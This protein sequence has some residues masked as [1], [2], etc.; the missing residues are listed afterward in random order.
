[1]NAVDL[2]AIWLC[3]FTVKVFSFSDAILE[4]SN[5]LETKYFGLQILEQLIQTRWKA[6]PREQCEGIKGYIVSMILDI[7]ADANKSE[8]MKL[9]L[10]K[11]NIVLVQI[12]KHEWPRLC[13]H[14]SQ[15]LLDQAEMDNLVLDNMT[16]ISL[17][18]RAIHL[19][20]QFCEQFESVHQLCHEILENADDAK[21]IYSTLQT[22]HGFL[23]WI[24]VGYIFE[25][26]MIDLIATK[27]PPAPPRIPIYCSSVLIEISS[28]SIDDN[29]QYGGKL[30]FLIHKVMELCQSRCPNCQ[31]RQSYSDGSHEEQNSFQIWRSFCHFSQGAFQTGRDHMMALSYLIKISQVED[32]EVFKICLDYW[33]SLAMELFRDSPFDSADNPLI[34]SLRRLRDTS[35]KNPNETQGENCTQLFFQSFVS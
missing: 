17:F 33:N 4:S 16:V 13:P 15:T 22:L 11:L 29:P 30:I 32:T 5:F 18:A 27:V 3:L 10:Q 34:D 19:K 8:S 2:T 28:I 7:S 35:S 6:L 24:P 1:M 14:L 31:F 21:L 26:N 25:N 12:V 9:L 20:Q 23:D